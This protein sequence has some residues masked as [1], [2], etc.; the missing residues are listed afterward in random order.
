MSGSYT[1]YLE[2]K[3]T[4]DDRSL[5]EGVWRAFLNELG[6]GSHANKNM[7]LLEIGAGT[8]GMLIKIIEAVNCNT[9]VYDV[10]DIESAHLEAL[11]TNVIQWGKLSGY[12]THRVSDDIIIAAKEEKQVE[13]TLYN[14]D[15]FTYL[16]RIGAREMYNAVIGQAIL[17]LLDI[18]Q[19]IKKVQDVIVSSGC[20]Y[21][22]INFDGMTSFMPLTLEKMDKL[23]EDI[24]HESMGGEEGYRRS[25]TGRRL[26]SHLLESRFSIVAAGGSDWVVVPGVSGAYPGDEKY[27]LSHILSLV[28]KELKASKKVADGEIQNWIKTRLQQLDEGKLIYIAHQVDVLARKQ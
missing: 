18:Q 6:A 1:R 20:M 19:A 12:S 25:S 16:G 21:F 4:I 27:F 7:H 5:N 11:C 15:I 10:V 17:D 9:M 13:I 22:P 28:E 24:Y 14:T 2:A 3:K 26:L 8:G 23:V